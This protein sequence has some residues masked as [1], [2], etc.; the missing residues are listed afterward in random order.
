MIT[1]NMNH[2][3]NTYT[4]KFVYSTVRQIATCSAKLRRR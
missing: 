3:Y 4:Y 2:T 1:S